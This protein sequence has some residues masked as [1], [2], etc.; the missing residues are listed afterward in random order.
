MQTME[1]ALNTVK[2]EVKWRMYPGDK[3]EEWKEIGWQTLQQNIFTYALENWKISPN[4]GKFSGHGRFDTGYHLE[5][6]PAEVKGEYKD[7]VVVIK[8]PEV[9]RFI[10]K[11]L[12][13]EVK[14]KQLDL[15]ELLAQEAMR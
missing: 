4:C 15:F 9:Q 11:M 7:M 10:H 5:A 6:S 2:A 13:D 8:W 14:D 1:F 3:Y 12:S